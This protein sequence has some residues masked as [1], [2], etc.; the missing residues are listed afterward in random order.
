M[1]CSRVHRSLGPGAGEDRRRSLALAL[2]TAA[3]AA[4]DATWWSRSREDAD[5]ATADIRRSGT[6]TAGAP[7]GADDPRCDADAAAAGFEDGWMPLP[8]A[9]G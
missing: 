4:I 2:Q 9:G 1:R 3:C 8:R 7:G 5:V 6:F